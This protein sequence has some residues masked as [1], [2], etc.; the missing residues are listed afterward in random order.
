M[1]LVYIVSDLI[2]D[3]VSHLLSSKCNGGVWCLREGGG[4]RGRID[5][6]SA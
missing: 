1:F 3:K 6:F 2:G 5:I 4:G